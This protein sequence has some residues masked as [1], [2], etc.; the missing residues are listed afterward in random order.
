MSSDGE[1]GLVRWSRKLVVVLPAIKALLQEHH[2]HEYSVFAVEY[3]RIARELGLPLNAQPP[4]KS[5][6]YYWISG[7]M[8]G[9]PKGYHCVVLEQ[10]FPG[11]TVKDLFACAPIRQHGGG[12]A[13][14]L[15]SIPSSL[16]LDH[17][18]GL[19]A[20]AF[21]F[22]EMRHV[23]LTTVTVAKNSVTA[24]NSPPPPRTEGNAVGFHN[25]LS[26]SLAGRH[27]IG[28]WRN[29]SDSYYYGGIHL[30][31]QPSETVMD[32]YYTSV[33]TDTQV[34]ANR[35]R[36][37]RV[38]PASTVGVDLA[39][40]TLAAPEDLYEVLVAYKPAAPPIPLAS[41][42]SGLPGKVLQRG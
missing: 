16:N 22:E 19:W 40:V 38:D 31:V 42:V 25:D 14:L 33:L 27:L 41:L 10:M 35:W 39:T 3:R 13:G 8:S 30:A 21:V 15:S 1:S 28:T 6:Y 26:L 9:L 34:V 36:W 32:G 23:D 20:T 18:A 4:G 12:E 17:L 11:W 7:Q 5:T 2:M 37:V 29:S 24:M